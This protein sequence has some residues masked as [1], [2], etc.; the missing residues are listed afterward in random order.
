[1]IVYRVAQLQYEFVP[2]SGLSLAM[3]NRCNICNR[4]VLL[5]L[6]YGF[7]RLSD[8]QKQDNVDVHLSLVVSHLVFFSLICNVQ[9][10]EYLHVLSPPPIHVL[11]SYVFSDCK[12]PFRK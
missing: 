11:A 9:I 1:M 4:C 3:R 12:F 10:T 8:N 2:I 6:S 7:G 5:F